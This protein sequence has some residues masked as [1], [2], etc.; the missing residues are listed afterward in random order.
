[1]V[2]NVHFKII[3]NQL[4][5]I[6]T[7]LPY[8]VFGT[9]WGKSLTNLVMPCTNPPPSMW[10]YF[11]YVLMQTQN[12]FIEKGLSMIRKKH[13]NRLWACKVCVCLCPVQYSAT[14][15][16]FSSCASF[17]LSFFDHEGQKWPSF[18]SLHIV[19]ITRNKLPPAEC[20]DLKNQDI[21]LVLVKLQWKASYA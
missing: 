11:N 3:M 12:C 10:N 19:A 14:Y 4:N 21:N 20:Q 18:N 6:N 16:Y 2:K 8:L 15:G 1:M 17:V 13:L 5:L 9:I 7:I